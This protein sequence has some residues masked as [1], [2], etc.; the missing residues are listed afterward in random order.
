M[1]LGSFSAFAQHDHAK[2]GHEMK[3][4]DNMVMFKDPNLNKAYGD[5]AQLKDALVASDKEEAKNAAV[6]LQKSLEKLDNGKDA[7]SEAT[8]VEKAESINDQREAFS[9][10]SDLMVSILKEGE[11]SMGM[12]Y[13]DYC[14]MA[15]ASWLSS[16]KEIRNPYYGEK[17][18][19]CGS[20][21]EMI[22]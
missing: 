15:K 13:I 18:L 12:I 2:S 6:Q 10:L 3:T 14:P 11:L 17:M 21:K 1:A 20:V 19:T 8:K 5:Y 4:N 16:D 9:S 22:H 7:A